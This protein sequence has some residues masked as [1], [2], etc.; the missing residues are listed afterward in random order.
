MK[1]MK[2]KIVSVLAVLFLGVMAFGQ[3]KYEKVMK[4]SLNMLDSAETL[5]THNQLANKFE[6]IALAEKDQWLAYYWSAYCYTISS[7]DEKIEAQQKD[8]YLDKALDYLDSAASLEGDLDEIHLLRS[9]TYTG[10]IIV[11][12]MARGMKFGPMSSEERAKAKAINPENPRYYYMEGINLVQTPAIWGGD[13][14]KGKKMLE[15]AIEKYEA[16]EPASDIHPDWGKDQAKGALKQ[17]NNETET[18]TPEAT[19][20]VE[21]APEG[22]PANSNTNAP[23]ETEGEQ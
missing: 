20:E 9:F 4:S 8:K 18:A 5:E 17:L 23:E 3:S 11:D 2:N 10:K 12:P 14:A 6:R 13:K 7:F 1:T 16:F 21:E 22:D 19:E 15:K